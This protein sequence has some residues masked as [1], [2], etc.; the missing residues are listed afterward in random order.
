MKHYPATRGDA[1]ST[2]PRGAVDGLQVA[3]QVAAALLTEIGRLWPGQAAKRGTDQEMI[4]SWGRAIAAHNVPGQ[5]LAAALTRL[6]GKPFPPD[7]G[8]LISAASSTVEIDAEA[9]LRRAARAAGEVPAA[10]YRL[11]PQEIWAA[12][13]FGGGE[14]RETRVSASDVK[15]WGGLLA[16]AAGRDLPPAPQKPAAL[17]RDASKPT[18]RVADEL[19]RALG[20]D[21]PQQGKQ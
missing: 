20:R 15:R 5:A 7:A 10:Y 4:M 16:E 18:H 9:S 6:S 19:W 21:K 14:L 2:A 11:S 8:A 12:R 3:T 17:I 13:Q 1:T